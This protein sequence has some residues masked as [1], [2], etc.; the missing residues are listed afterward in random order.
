MAEYLGMTGLSQQRRRTSF[1][2]SG[3]HR[4]RP[5]LVDMSGSELDQS[6]HTAS[7]SANAAA[8]LKYEEISRKPFLDRTLER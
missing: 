7:D 2:R 1:L 8:E 6:A 3:D 4:N 5:I